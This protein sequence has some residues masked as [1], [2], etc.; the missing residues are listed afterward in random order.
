MLKNLPIDRQRLL[1][2]NINKLLRY[3]STNRVLQDVCSL[4]GYEQLNL[5]QHYLVKKHVLDVNGN[6]VFYTKQIEDPTTNEMI[7]VPDYRRMYE[8]YFHSVDINEKNLA[9][10]FTNA[11]SQRQYIDIVT[12][13]PI[14]GMKMMNC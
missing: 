13:D 4:L 8:I 10:A 5:V 7:E 3:K 9:L 11:T 1:V 12:S 6:P 2:R 14:G